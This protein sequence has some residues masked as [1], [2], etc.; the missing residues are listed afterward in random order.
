[1]PAPVSHELMWILLFCIW[2]SLRYLDILLLTLAHV[3]ILSSSCF[4]NIC[5]PFDIDSGL[6][7][8]LL[9]PFD[10]PPLH[11]N[12]CR[13]WLI[14][15]MALSLAPLIP[16]LVLCATFLH[17]IYCRLSIFSI[18]TVSRLLS[19]LLSGLST[20]RAATISSAI[21]YYQ[22]QGVLGRKFKGN[23]FKKHIKTHARKFHVG[24]SMW[25]THN[26][27]GLNTEAHPLLCLL[28]P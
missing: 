11:H 20:D 10:L 6:P 22:L 2:P 17:K 4:L 13:L 25:A 1:M 16:M 12:C 14:L 15:P 21:R 5:C 19:D 18:L 27:V 7:C 23:L 26:C 28:S 8:T 9:I 24:W 3:L